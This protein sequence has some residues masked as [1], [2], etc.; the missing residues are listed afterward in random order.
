MGER[1]NQ[2]QLKEKIQN[3]VDFSSPDIRIRKSFNVQVKNHPA[4]R[5]VLGCSLKETSTSRPS[6]D[7]KTIKR[8]ENKSLA[9]E[10]R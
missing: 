3:L 2:R 6:W 5:C 8:E 4:Y 9:L 1:I 10:R 7:V